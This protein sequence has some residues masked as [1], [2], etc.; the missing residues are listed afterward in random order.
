MTANPGMFFYGRSDIVAAL[1]QHLDAVRAQGQGRIVA[2]RGRRQVGKSTAVDTFVRGTDVPYVFAAGT[3]G[4][5]TRTQ[6]ADATEALTSSTRPLPGTEVTQGLSLQTWRDW[7]RA[8]EVAARQGP[9]VVVLDEFPWAVAADPSLEGTLQN[10]WDQTLE[11]LPVLVVLVG[12]DVAMMDRLSEYGRALYGR[13]RP[14]VVDPLNPAEIAQALPDAT[15]TEIFDAYLVTGGYPRLV[16]DLARS[17]GG[18]SQYV[19]DSFADLY[20]PL[21]STA[22]FTLDAE[23]P[24]SPA[25][26]RVLSTIGANETTAPRFND[27]IPAGLEDAEVTRYQTAATRAL[28]VLTDDKRLVT[29]EKPVWAPEKGRLRRYRVTDPYLRFWFRY[30]DPSLELISRGRA[31]HAFERFERDWSSWRGRSI[32]PVVR[33]SLARLAS[34]D[35][36]LQSVEDVGAWWTR[37]GQTEVDVAAVS[38]ERTVLLGTIKWRPDG[39]ISRREVEHLRAAAGKVPRSADALLA[40][41]SPDG[42]PVEGADLTYGAA[43]LLAGWQA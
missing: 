40:A 8:I 13:V 23:F 1:T 11:H 3:L 2:M 26:A 17:D 10:V 12:S 5:P 7:F 43:D 22:R 19:A 18:V 9:A 28:R 31:D 33:E 39:E 6:V 20:S 35:P 21:V 32:E 15:P 24:D 42:G 37:D 25:A 14:L 41:I 38:R 27:L 16:T 29:T 4:A 34:D 30:V 36:R